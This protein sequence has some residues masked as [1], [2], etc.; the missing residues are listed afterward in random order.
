[1]DDDRQRFFN[2][3]VGKWAAILPP[4]MEDCALLLFD[5][6]MHVNPDYSL[7]SDEILPDHLHEAIQR[8]ILQYLVDHK[9]EPIYLD[10]EQTRSIKAP[11]TT[12]TTWQSTQTRAGLQEAQ[13]RNKGRI[14]KRT[15][16][17][18]TAVAGSD[19]CAQPEN[20][21]SKG[22]VK[23]RG[24]VSGPSARPKART[25]AAEPTV[26][27]VAGPSTRAKTRAAPAVPDVPNI[28]PAAT[29]PLT[30]KSKRLQALRSGA[31]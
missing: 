24:S 27:P 5:I 29:G 28:E 21:G 23:Q 2:Y 22:E 3:T 4:E 30:R 11:K 1:M 26:G 19:H 25:A 6:S 20:L 17:Q 10:P 7:W 15:A 16:T 12:G 14:P 13:S 9:N 8:L 18:T 31:R